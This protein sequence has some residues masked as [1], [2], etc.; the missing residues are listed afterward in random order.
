MSYFC[1]GTDRNV[2]FETLLIK[3][4]AYFYTVLHIRVSSEVSVGRAEAL[5]IQLA[6]QKMEVAEFFHTSKQ[7]RCNNPEDKYLGNNAGGGGGG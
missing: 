3:F 4:S 7:T 6:T 1:Q 2:F 5:V